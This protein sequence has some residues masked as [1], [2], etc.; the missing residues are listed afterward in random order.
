MTHACKE[1][2]TLRISPV[3][4]QAGPAG[5]PDHFVPCSH[6]A[7]F[8][9]LLWHAC[10]A[11]AHVH[12]CA[13]AARPLIPSGCALPCPQLLSLANAC[14]CSH[15]CRSPRPSSAAGRWESPYSLCTE[16]LNTVGIPRA[17]WRTGTE[18]GRSTAHVC[19]VF[20]AAL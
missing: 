17:L 11:S 2:H 3:Q 15:R 18:F 6:P 9:R 4:M 19:T 8:A 1:K 7:R 5:A 13:G 10:C 20:L 16:L 14:R 12:E